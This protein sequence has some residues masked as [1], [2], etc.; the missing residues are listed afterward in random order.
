VK[1]E[2]SKEETA[3]TIHHVMHMHHVAPTNPTE[4]TLYSLSTADLMYD[5]KSRRWVQRPNT[6]S[7][8]DMVPVTVAVSWESYKDLGRP[9]PKPE[10][11]SKSAEVQ[12]TGVADTGCTVLCAGL[13]MMRKLR[14]PQSVLGAIP[15]VIAVTGSESNT[16]TQFLHILSELSSLFISKTCLKELNILSESIPLPHKPGE[17]AHA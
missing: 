16:I 6:R 4:H 11:L 17:T 8:V 14:I 2:K 5:K 13:E 12:T 3:G 15:V 1:E 10:M 7:K 9:V